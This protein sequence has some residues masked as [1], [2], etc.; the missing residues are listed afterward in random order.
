MIAVD[1]NVVLRYLLQD[2][3]RQSPKANKL[4]EGDEKILITDVVLAETIWTLRGKRYELSKEELVNVVQAL[5]EESNVIFEDG[6]AI[7]CALDDYINASGSDFS[8]ALIINKS[9]RFG[10]KTKQTVYPVYTFDK[11]A[12]KIDG[13][14]KP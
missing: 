13:T 10:T 2:D 14:K 1:T 4:F 11:G 3:D 7:W 8:D 5:I 9:Q 6:H 12:L